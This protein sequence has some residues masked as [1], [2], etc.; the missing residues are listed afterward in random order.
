[1]FGMYTWFRLSSK[2]SYNKKGTIPY[3]INLI[4]HRAKFAIRGLTS[5]LPIMVFCKT[6]ACDR[7][8]SKTLSHWQPTHSSNEKI[9]EKECFIIEESKI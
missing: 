6:L 7:I 5:F 2:Y 4:S 1:M 9:D 8:I 3:F